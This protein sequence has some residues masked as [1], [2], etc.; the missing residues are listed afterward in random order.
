[1]NLS[2][3]RGLMVIQ[4]PCNMEHED[5]VG[6]FWIPN[7][8]ILAQPSKKS[9]ELPEKETFIRFYNASTALTPSWLLTNVRFFNED[10]N[11]DEFLVRFIPGMENPY[12]ELSLR[13]TEPI[14]ETAF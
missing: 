7:E 14:E 8:E 13:N 3:E 11:D 2:G 10:Q 1:M 12:F 6:P 5:F 9:F 4:S